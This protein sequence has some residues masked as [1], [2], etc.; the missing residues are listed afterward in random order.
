LPASTALVGVFAGVKYTDNKGNITYS[1][2]WPTGQLATNIE[3]MVYDD[4]NITFEIQTDATGALEVDKGA[5]ANVEI[6]AGEPTIG[7]SK[8]N[9]D[10]S[11]G[12]AA[13]GKAFRILRLIDDGY[14]EPG[15]FS[16][17]EVAFATHALKGVVAGVGGV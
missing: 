9:L 15:P 10:V 4:P 8:T 6:V 1:G 12:L 13:V 14:N 3:A 5:L 2:Y 16:R 7:Q 11:A 17:V